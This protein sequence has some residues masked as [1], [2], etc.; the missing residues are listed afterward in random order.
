MDERGVNG[1][2][3]SGFARRLGVQPPALF[4]YFDSLAAL[5][6]ELFRPGPPST[7]TRCARP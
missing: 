5:Y 2:G 4:E 6:D 7:S 1:L 3:L